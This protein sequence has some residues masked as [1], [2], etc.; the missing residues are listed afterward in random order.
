MNPRRKKR[1]ILASAIFGGFALVIGLIIYGLKAEADWFYVPSE[2]INGSKETGVKPKVG[3]R[4]RIG[5]MVVVGSVKRDD[6]SLEVAFDLVDSG[7]SVT[8]V[9][10]GILPDLFREGQGIVADGVLISPTKLQ[11]SQV[12]AKHDE[13][14]MP[15][16][17][18]EGMKSYGYEGNYKKQD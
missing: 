4:I 10:K 17:M 3:D 6:E 5:G 12:L 11:A 1:L 18:A 7:P 14:Y 2:V 9:Y 16:D 15:K 13:N 8:V